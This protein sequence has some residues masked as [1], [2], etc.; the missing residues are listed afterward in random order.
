MAATLYRKIPGFTENFSPAY[1]GIWGLAPGYPAAPGSPFSICQNFNVL[2]LSRAPRL[3]GSR[4]LLVLSHAP[5]LV[6]R[7]RV[8]FALR[9]VHASTVGSS[10]KTQRGDE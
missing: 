2:S 10:A 8:R 5:A 9:A 7:F 6:F 3:S 4:A 1:G